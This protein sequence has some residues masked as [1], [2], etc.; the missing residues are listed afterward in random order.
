MAVGYVALALT[1]AL[2]TGLEIGSQPTYLAL[3]PFIVGLGG[4]VFLVISAMAVRRCADHGPGSIGQVCFWSAVLLGFT[5]TLMYVTFFLLFPNALDEGE[6]VSKI[7]NIPPVIAAVWAAGI[8]WYVH[9]QATAKAHRTN[10]AFNL[11]MQT[12]TN[13]EFI[14]RSEL[15]Q[16]YFPHGSG[17]VEVDTAPGR[18]DDRIHLKSL[19]DQLAAAEARKWPTAPY[20]ELALLRD[21]IGRVK[22]QLALRYMLNFYEVMAV[23]IAKNDLDEGLLYDSLGGVVPSIY[24]RAEKII[25]YERTKG[26]VAVLVFTGLTPLVDR[27][28][29]KNEAERRKLEDTK[30]A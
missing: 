28:E 29:R 27:W 12:R 11:L 2:C 1:F 17:I 20:E 7:L 19:E 26:T 21:R 3:K 13:K 10:N 5:V 30:K 24:R 6:A 4:F 15:I 8:G 9:F 25:A 16:R 22:A 14:D 18:V 23:A